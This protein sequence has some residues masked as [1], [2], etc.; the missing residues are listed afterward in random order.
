MMN[1]AKR[2]S[3]RYSLAAGVLFTMATTAWALSPE[4]VATIGGAVAVGSAISSGEISPDAAAQLVK[5]F[6]KDQMS[7]SEIAN[8]FKALRDTSVPGAV[9]ADTGV[10]R[11]GNRGMGGFVQDAHARGLRGRALAEAIHAEQARRGI[12][13]HTRM[14]DTGVR[15]TSV[16]DNRAADGKEKG[17]P[18][19]SRKNAVDK[20]T[21][22]ERGRGHGAKGRS[23]NENRG[24]R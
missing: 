23:K 3:G 20:D 17:N 1:I 16:R 22:E 10:G 24:N 7:N 21:G 4:T 8:I 19:H 9:R 6:R 11:G 12:P 15:D 14:R 5:M 2:R 18:H 13:G